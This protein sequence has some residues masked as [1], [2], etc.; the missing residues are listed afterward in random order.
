MK[1]YLLK[2]FCYCVLISVIFTL[3][4]INDKKV[5]T[6]SYIINTIA[7]QSSVP[8]SIYDNMIVYDGLSLND[9]SLKIDH[10]LN[11]TLA[12]YG[13]TIATLALEN[14]VDPLIATS[15]ILVETGCKWNCSY[16]AKNCYNFGGMKGKGCGSYAKFASLDAGLEA[17][18]NN[19][20]KNY[21][22]KGLTTPEAI[23]TKYAENPNWH[24]DINYY[25]NLIKAS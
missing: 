4:K 9:L 21:F 1:Q 18:I 15:I 3:V 11:S 13:K 12:G 14:D 19:L 8:S 23:N 16:L 10:V 22:Q 6:H 24:N 2:M 20:S 17:F 25:I 5:L 7:T